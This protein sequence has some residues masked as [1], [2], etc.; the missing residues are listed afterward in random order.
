MCQPTR[1][2]VTPAHM[3]SR[4]PSIQSEHVNPLP[5]THPTPPNLTQSL[6][7]PRTCDMQ[8]SSQLLKRHPMTMRLG[9]C[10]S[11]N[12]PCTLPPNITSLPPGVAC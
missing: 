1:V 4:C 8:P 11:R 10:S 7:A 9:G 3:A 2:L 12:S 6:P 5:P